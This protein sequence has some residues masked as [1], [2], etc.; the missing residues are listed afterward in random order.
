MAVVLYGSLAKETDL[1]VK[2]EE[3]ARRKW[4]AHSVGCAMA[5]TELVELL[6]TE[7]KKRQ[8]KPTAV[9]MTSRRYPLA[10]GE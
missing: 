6:S 5:S 7:R 8:F 4:V 1:A 2:R 10:A 9:G 3:K